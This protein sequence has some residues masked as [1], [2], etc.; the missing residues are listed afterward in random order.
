MPRFINEGSVDN[1]QG[2]GL[3]GGRSLPEGGSNSASGAVSEW[4]SEA[5]TALF[6][7]WA[8][9]FEK[10]STG[11]N[12]PYFD[13]FY[14]GQ[15]IQISID[16]LTDPGDNLP[17][18]AFG[19]NIQQ[20]KTPLYGFWSYTFDAM[21]RG[22]RIITGAFSVVSTTPHLLTTLIA[23]AASIRALDHSQN[24]YALRGLEEDE[25]HIERYWSRN[26]TDRNLDIAQK[27]LFSIHPPFN[28]VIQ[29][30]LQDTSVVA[31]SPSARAKEIKDKFYDNDALMQDTN[32]RL[33]K[34]PI[35]EL[36]RRILLENIE[37]MSKSVEYN[38]D[39]DPLLE[40]YTFM[41]RDERLVP[42]YA[43]GVTQAR[44]GADVED[45]S[46]QEA[47]S[48]GGNVNYV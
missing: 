30:G 4:W 41:A 33:V 42:R 13:Y 29:Y 39:G 28:F 5:Q 32:E 48:R 40:T 18:Y 25:A 35:P 1:G 14:T 19:Y 6:T 44:A 31:K 12:N 26:L 43:T 47:P 34:H 2:A 17:I 8:S 9:A 22:T 36:N 23:K 21:L 45:T 16:G 11:F 20:Q 7:S 24:I 46:R 10:Y 15:D 37:L 38:V 27:H 3:V